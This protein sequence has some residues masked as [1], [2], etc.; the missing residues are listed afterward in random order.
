MR[1]I[2]PG[3]AAVAALM[4]AAACDS[5]DGPLEEAGE[6]IDEAFDEATEDLDDN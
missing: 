4:L 6:N 2:K 3:V 5:N 1:F